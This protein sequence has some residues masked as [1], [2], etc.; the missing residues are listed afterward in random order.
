MPPR[1]TSLLRTAVAI[2]LILASAWALHLLGWL[3]PV[4]SALTFVTE[5]VAVALR[6]V[7]ERVGSALNLLGRIGQLDAEN[8]KLHQ[9]L[10]QSKTRIGQLEE[11]TAELADLRKRLD[12]PLPPEIKTTVATV[13]GHDG[14]S[15]TKRLTIDRGSADGLKEGMA[16]LSSGGVLVGR[17]QRV[18][19]GSAEVL[20]LADDGSAVPT[21]IAESRATGILHGE[22]G[23]G[24]K[25]TDIP[26][27][28]TV[29]VGDQVQT[30]GLGGDVPKGLP[31]G[32]VEAVETAANALFQT[33]RVRPFVDVERLEFVH[34]VTTF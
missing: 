12:A 20:L 3:R 21:R 13:I 6:T 22:L 23:L 14:I 27:S 25:M 15:G 4:E 26:Q 11:A 2:A 16:V 30:S 19:A 28:D 5:P 24:L 7:G 8:A 9:D 10:E 29:N 32:T 34:I 18:L 1:R 17:I 33:V 31:I